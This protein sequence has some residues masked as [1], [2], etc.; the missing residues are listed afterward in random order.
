MWIL[1]SYYKGCVELWSR[2]RSLSR[3]IIHYP[4]SFYLH[5]KDLH[6]YWEMIEGLSS[7][8]KIEECSFNTIFGTFQ[9]HRIFAG[10]NCREDRGTDTLRSRAAK[11]L[12]SGVQII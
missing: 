1:D 7:R 5:L 3:T 4:Q 12:L 10:K 8:F 9:G 11:S 2:E 6:A